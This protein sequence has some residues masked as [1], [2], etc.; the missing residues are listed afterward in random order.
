V[1]GDLDALRH[2]VNDSITAT[3]EFASELT[4]QVIALEELVAARWP[5]SVLVRARLRRDL[6]ASVRHPDG[7]DFT[8]RR[9]N[10]LASG[11]MG[12]R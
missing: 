11:W 3:D 10:S 2:E 8:E 9:I 1:N 5:R 4:R 6:R 12:R 7:S